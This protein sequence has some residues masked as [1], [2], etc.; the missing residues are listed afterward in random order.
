MR[1]STGMSTSGR[2][3]GVKRE[4]EH[5]EEHGDDNKDEGGGEKEPGNLRS[6]IRGGSEDARGEAT[7]TSNQQAQ[8]QHLMLK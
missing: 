2:G 5:V 8:P 6:G 4:R 7:P 1:K 3:M